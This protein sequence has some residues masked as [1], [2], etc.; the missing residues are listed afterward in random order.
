MKLGFLASGGGTNMQA[1][2][3]ACKE[4]RLHAQPAVV[5][6]NNSH[7]GALQRACNE[8]IPWFHFSS[9]THPNAGDLDAAIEGALL[10]HEVEIVCLAGYLKLLGPRTILTYK[11]RIL[12]IHPALLPKFGGGGFYGCAVHEAVLA[13]GER[14]SGASVHLVDEAYDHGP[15]IAQVRVP[16]FLGDTPEILAARVL[17]QEHV[18]YTETLQK[19]A[20]GEINL[21]SFVFDQV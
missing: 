10:E 5:I 19:I 18:L 4:G 2:I 3:D 7:S 20:A 11:G 15:V 14:E 16:V 1:I 6:G 21:T 8:R 13:A 12:N 9:K 17:A